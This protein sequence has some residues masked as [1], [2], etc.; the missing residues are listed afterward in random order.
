MLR[1]LKFYPD[2]IARHW[3]KI[4]YAI[5]RALPPIVDSRMSNDR[6]NKILESILAG[7]I[8]VHVFVIYEDEHPIVYGIM[9]TALTNAVDSDNKEL[10]I[11]SAYAS[12]SLSRELIFEALELV[13]KY[14]KSQGCVAIS[15]YTNIEGV[16]RLFE[17]MGGSSSFTYLRLE[18]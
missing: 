9:S 4:G 13:R 6:M 16:K 8:E 5:E 10:L 14:A 3:G 18:V 15:G 11:Y 12:K 2:Q 17:I 7:K 1:M